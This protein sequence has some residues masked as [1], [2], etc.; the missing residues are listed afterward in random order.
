[1]RMSCKWDGKDRPRVLIGRHNNDCEDEG[2]K[3][4]QACV[5]P[6]CRVCGMAHGLGACAECLAAIRAD[7]HEI[8]RMCD[9][10]PEEVEHRGI[11]GEAMMLLAPAADPEAI[12]HV[13]ASIACGRLPADYLESANHE[14]HPLFVLGS[15]DGVWRDALEH[16]E[17]NQR[18][19][20]MVAVDYLDR[21]MSYMG[22]FEHVPFEDFAR[23]LRQCVAHMESVLHDGEQIDRGAPCM[24]CKIPLVRVWG[25][26]VTADGWRCPRCNRTSTEDQ[27]RFAVKADHLAQGDW[28]TA[29]DCSELT[30]QADDIIGVTPGTIRSWATK[31]KVR[32]RRH[33]GRTVYNRADV[34]KHAG[35]TTLAS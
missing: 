22:G 24:T 27:Y 2:C 8:A 26:D 11:D 30:I 7:L 5:E 25:K 10:L 23:D 21:T 29:A 4:C 18:L 9:S 15:W 28:L 3:G 1:M 13:Q 32:K 12:G 31:G 14:K 17:P 34:L 35:S 19:T 16:D 6:H 20:L 33:S